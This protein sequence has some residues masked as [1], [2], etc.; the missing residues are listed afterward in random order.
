MRRL[1]GAGLMVSGVMACP[2]HLIVTLPVLVG[3]LAGTTLG[4]VL[5]HHTGLIY[6]GTGLYFVG[7]L[8]LG[9]WCWFGPNRPKQDVGAACSTCEPGASETHEQ[10]PFL[11][12][13]D[14]PAPK[15]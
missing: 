13:E 7:A 14:R 11:M 10:E 12:Q 9:Y 15:R 6:T 8:A 1:S 5:T 3:L 2:C 4:D